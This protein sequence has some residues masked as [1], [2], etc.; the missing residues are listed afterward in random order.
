MANYYEGLKERH[1]KLMPYANAIQGFEKGQYNP[2]ELRALSIDVAPDEESK[3]ALQNPNTPIEVVYNFVGAG[4]ETYSKNFEDYVNQNFALIINDTDD[5]ILINSLP[6]V[7][8]RTNT[9][10]K[11]FNKIGKLHNKTRE[12]YSVFSTYN[13]EKLDENTKETLLNNM[14]GEVID[15]YQGLYSDNKALLKAL[16][17]LTIYSHDFRKV[18]YTSLTSQRVEELKDRVK[19]RIKPYL[20]GVV[21]KDD[22]KGLCSIISQENI[23]EFGLKKAA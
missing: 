6:Y 1:K 14:A 8:P 16:T 23:P 10:N 18:K 21:K 20:R 3:Q 7:S 5:K 2:L 13:Q 12:M 15:Y 9:K 19:G 11:E 4:A 22:R 17:S